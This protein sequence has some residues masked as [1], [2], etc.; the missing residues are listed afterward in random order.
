MSSDRPDENL[1]VDSD[2]L[3]LI[4][5]DQASGMPQE[6]RQRFAYADGSV[7]LLAR[8]G[9]T[10]YRNL[11]TDRGVVVRIQRR[12]FRGKARL[13]DARERAAIVSRTSTLFRRKYG[14]RGD[15]DQEGAALLPVTIDIQF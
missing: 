9:E 5:A 14:R 7:H 13:P 11:E 4:T 15:P 1:L 6:T 10:W 12:G 2:E 3:I 8:A